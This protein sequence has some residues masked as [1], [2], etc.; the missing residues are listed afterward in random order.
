MSLLSADEIQAID[1]AGRRILARTGIRVDDDALLGRLEREGARVDRASRRARM[2][3]D[4]LDEMIARAPRRFTLHARD[5]RNDLHLGEDKV[6]FGSGGRVFHIV[7]PLTGESRPS[8]LEDVVVSAILVD[9]LE[10]IRFYLIPCQAHDLD[11]ATYHLNDFFHAFHHTTKHVMGG[12]GDVQGAEQIW[13]LA[14]HIAGGE[15]AYRDKPFMSVITNMMSPLIINASTVQV[16]DHLC[17]RGVPVTCAP[18][19]IAGATAPATLAGT[20]AQLHA[21]ALAGVAVTQVLVPGCRVLYGAVATTMD[22]RK[23]DYAMGSV[24]MAMMNAAAV[25]LA[26]LHRLPIYASSGVT[27]AKRPD[28]QAGMEKML[29]NLLVGM[30]GGDYIHLA[31]GMVD[32]GNAISHEQLVIDDEGLALVERVLAGIRVQPDTLAVDVIDR[33]GPGGNYVTDDHT[34]EHMMDEFFYPVLGVRSNFTQWTSLGKPDMLS[35]A[36]LRIEEIRADAPPG[37]L[38]AGLV[39]ALKSAF[40]GIRDA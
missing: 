27:D 17:N 39:R 13:K 12:C 35:R 3:A 21:E 24:E 15:D 33:V 38:D 14:T 28:I 30:A 1:Q 25:K 36:R 11:P 4:W 9:S 31:A 40:P 16:L 7:D 10:H 29:S 26:K 20:L 37:L 6:H 18:A 8:L 34:V 23:M 19:P 5:G 32:S 2:D 22:L